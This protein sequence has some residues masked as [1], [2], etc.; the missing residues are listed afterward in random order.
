MLVFSFIHIDLDIRKIKMIEKLAG[1]LWYV[2]YLKCSTNIKAIVKGFFFAA[3]SE[4]N[5]IVQSYNYGTKSKVV[6]SLLG[7]W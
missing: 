6:A 2:D 5:Q 7:R 1:S 4:K 3:F